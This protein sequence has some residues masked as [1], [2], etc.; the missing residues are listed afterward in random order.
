MVYGAQDSELCIRKGTGEDDISGDY[1]V[2]EKEEEMTAGGKTV[3]TKANADGIYTVTWTEEGY[4]FA[5]SCDTPMT[6]EMVGEL[7]EQV[8]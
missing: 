5:V 3:L 1:E 6:E 2:Y 4:A 7:T 8:R